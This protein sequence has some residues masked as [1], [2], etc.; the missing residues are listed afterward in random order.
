MASD[1]NSR[2]VQMSF[3][4]YLINLLIQSWN[5]LQ[6]SSDSLCCG[7]ASDFKNKS[8]NL[9]WRSF[10]VEGTVE[11]T[12]PCQSLWGNDTRVESGG[13]SRECQFFTSF[14]S[15][16]YS[17][18]IGILTYEWGVLAIKSSCGAEEK[19]KIKK[20]YF[21]WSE[22]F[23]DLQNAKCSTVWNK[24]LVLLLISVIINIDNIISAI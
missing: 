12:Y 16:Q 11:D 14:V 18:K 24:F 19:D 9:E 22:W 4:H 17:F 5:H 20:Q 6:G 1:G 15:V 10:P 8:S 2:W 21:I 7:S 23:D 13:V 3:P